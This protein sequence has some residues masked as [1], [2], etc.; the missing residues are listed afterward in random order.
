MLHSHF[1]NGD[2]WILDLPQVDFN[3]YRMSEKTERGGT[4]YNGPKG[5]PFSGF[6]YIKG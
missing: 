3:F 1:K 2:T 6:R 5:V 4:P